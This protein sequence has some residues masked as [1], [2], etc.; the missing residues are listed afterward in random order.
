MQI[1]SS[2]SL[3]KIDYDFVLFFDKYIS[4]YPFKCYNMMELFTNKEV[5]YTKDTTLIINLIKVSNDSLYNIF[6]LFKDLLRN[7]IIS[8]IIYKKEVLIIYFKSDFIMSFFK[9]RNKWLIIPLISVLLE[10]E[11]KFY[12]DVFIKNII[13]EKFMLLIEY[14]SFYITIDTVN[15]KKL[16]DVHIPLIINFYNNKD[17]NLKFSFDKNVFLENL[18]FKVS[19]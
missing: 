3:K 19:G 8:K 12:F 7:N 5:V 2:Y 1:I 14:K 11:I 18:N 17:Q 9:I 16:D 10:L 13:V 15:N 4:S 6:S